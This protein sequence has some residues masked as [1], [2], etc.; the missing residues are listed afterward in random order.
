[1]AIRYA[2]LSVHYR[3]QLNFTFESLKEA[4]EVIEKLDN[5]Y[6]QC[7]S[8]SEIPQGQAVPGFD[9]TIL[10]KTIA[11]MGKVLGEDLNIAL[12][13]AGLQEA[14]TFINAHLAEISQEGFADCLDFFVKVDRLLG[15]YIASVDA[16]PAPVKSSLVQYAE[17]RKARDFTTSD[18]MR[19]KLVELGW[20]VKDGRP[21]EPSTVKKVRRTWDIK[22]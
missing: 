9:L 14:V 19:Q 13:L 4:R 7:L 6:F 22:K 20:L 8:R 1:M 18:L 16:I 11:E 5:C 21:G 12:A 10:G 17:A 2:L 15:F 3:H